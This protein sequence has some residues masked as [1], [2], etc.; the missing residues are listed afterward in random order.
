MGRQRFAVAVVLLVLVACAH[1]QTAA[2]SESCVI[3]KAPPPSYVKCAEAI[4]T[5][6]DVAKSAKVD[7]AGAVATLKTYPVSEGHE[8]PAWWVTW[9]DMQ[10][11][12]EQGSSCA[13]ESFFVMVDAT[14]GAVLA[15]DVP[16]CPQ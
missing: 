13:P 10:Y 3:E 4:S 1:D 14:D 12:P 11:Q 15:H 5:A 16:N 7:V 9:A 2:T 6:E 8:H